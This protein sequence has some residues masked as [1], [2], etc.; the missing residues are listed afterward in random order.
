MSN[1]MLR[2]N[3]YFLIIET[4]SIVLLIILCIIS[5]LN[6]FKNKRFFWFKKKASLAV[7][8]RFF[9]FVNSWKA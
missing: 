6:L 9:R 1:E 7:I 4:L 5:L 2:S 8:D 3:Y